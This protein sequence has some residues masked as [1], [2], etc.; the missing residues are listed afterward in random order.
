MAGGKGK[1]TGADGVPFKKNDPR[2][3]KEGRPIKLPDLDSLLIDVLGEEI[4]GKQAIK[5]M[6]IAL[7]KK[8]LSGDVR[9]NEILL[10][11][12]FGRVKNI[13]DLSLNIELLTENE[14]D[15]I[16]TRLLNKQQ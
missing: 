8:A 12:K 7:R 4:K 3:N 15:L 10:D 6:L 13:T 1:I 5:Q 14:L 2:I 11:R 16:I 9:A